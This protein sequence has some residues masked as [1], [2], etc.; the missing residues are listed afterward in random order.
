[1]SKIDD[2]SSIEI[3]SNLALHEFVT[4]YRQAI[5]ELVGIV[6]LAAEETKSAL[7]T[8][9]AS[10]EIPASVRAAKVTSHLE[11]AGRELIYSVI[12]MARSITAFEEMYAEE[13]ERVRGK[14]EPKKFD[15]S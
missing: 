10:G 3:N 5:Y 11:S 7:V 15:I 8:I 2:L 13:I 4:K 9:P 1:M 12:D 14:P 6:E